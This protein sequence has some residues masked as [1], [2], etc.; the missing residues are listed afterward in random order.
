MPSRN[1]IFDGFGYGQ[2]W[3]TRPQMGSGYWHALGQMEAL[4]RCARDYRVKWWA[5]PNTFDPAVEIPAR[6]TAYYAF[7]VKPGSYLYGWNF[8][9]ADGEVAP[10]DASLFGIRMVD[11]TSGR[12]LQNFQISGS[13]FRSPTG[14]TNVG[15]QTPAFTEVPPINLLNQPRLI[16]GSGELAVE[17]VNNDTT[18]RACQ[19]LLCFAEPRRPDVCLPGSVEC[20]P[21]REPLAPR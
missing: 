19:L 6:E 2:T 7:L 9:A 21:P 13:F 14:G 12:L 10:T 11:A 3:A 20:Y 18:E 16:S 8:T 5:V 15:A 4:R 1:I 17:I